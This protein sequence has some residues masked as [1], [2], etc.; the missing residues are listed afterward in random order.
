MSVPNSRVYLDSIYFP[1]RAG[2]KTTGIE[3]AGLVITTPVA[4]VTITG[5]LFLLVLLTLPSKAKL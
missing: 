4:R 2:P 1:F 3:C 5:L